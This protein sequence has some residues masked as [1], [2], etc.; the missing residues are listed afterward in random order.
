MLWMRNKKKNN[1][2]I[3]LV[4]V[5]IF[6]ASGVR[7]GTWRQTNRQT[8]CSFHW[9]QVSNLGQIVLMPHSVYGSRCYRDS[10]CSTLLLYL[11]LNKIYLMR[12]QKISFAVRV[13]ELFDRW[14]SE[15]WNHVLQRFILDLPEPKSWQTHQKK[16][17]CRY[18]H[19]RFAKMILG[20]ASRKLNK[21]YMTRW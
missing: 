17:F 3:L 18:L 10:T 14:T 7:W 20:L 12:V 21:Q 19:R 6:R 5:H 9:Q 4:V 15:P 13:I 1:S 2:H 16:F 8:E 11:L